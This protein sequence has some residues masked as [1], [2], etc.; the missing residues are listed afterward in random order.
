MP[1]KRLARSNNQMIAGVCS[2]IAE[3]LNLDPTI[4]RVLYALFTIATGGT[5]IL[6]YVILWIIMPL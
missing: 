2:G 6:I 4:V 1:S 5:G 3:F